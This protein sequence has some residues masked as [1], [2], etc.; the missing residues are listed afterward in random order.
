MK[1]IMIALLAIAVL[2]GFA[3]CDNSTPSDA[4]QVTNVYSK[5]IPAYLT[6]EKIDLADFELVGEDQNGNIVDIDV[7]DIVVVDE[8]KL[9]AAD[10]AGRAAVD[11]TALSY[12]GKSLGAIYYDAYTADANSLKVVPSSTTNESYF[13]NTITNGFAKFNYGNYVVT[14]TYT[15]GDGQKVTKTLDAANGDYTVKFTDTAV[16]NDVQVTFT[17]LVGGTLTDGSTVK[18]NVKA[19]PVKGI[20]A[21]LVSPWTTIYSRSDADSNNY[22]SL[23]EAFATHESGYTETTKLTQNLTYTPATGFITGED[24]S[25]VYGEAGEYEITVRYTSGVD[26]F[27]AKVSVPVAEDYIKSITATAKNDLA[28]TGAGV[29]SGTQLNKTDFE[30]KATYASGYTDADQNVLDVADYTINPEVAPTVATGVTSATVRVSLVDD[31][32]VYSDVAI[33]ITNA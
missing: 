31:A 15:D 19:D 6:G 11:S 28:S 16:A 29:A 27:N 17:T 21:K 33:K 14:V 2:F 4:G 13:E 5:N 8:S 3:A 1:K 10:K 32:T 25:K 30:V 24:G 18:V 20:S 26:A 7:A 23:I 9:V 22:A 12:K